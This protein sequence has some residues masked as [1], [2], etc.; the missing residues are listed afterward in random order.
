MILLLDEMQEPVD[1][2]G[3]MGRNGR[4]SISYSLKPMLDMSEVSSSSQISGHPSLHADEGNER[5][6]IG[7]KN[8]E[9]GKSTAIPFM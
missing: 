5:S 2:D 6:A 8:E 7:K 9:I 4:P 1:T 3:H